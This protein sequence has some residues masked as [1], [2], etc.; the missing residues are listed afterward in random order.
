MHFVGMYV[1]VYKKNVD[2]QRIDMHKNHVD[3]QYEYLITSTP[4]G[5]LYL[6]FLWPWGLCS[7]L[8]LVAWPL[9]PLFDMHVRIDHGLDLDLSE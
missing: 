7:R 6:I 5:C 2:M 3:K 8:C 9:E 4:P 1:E